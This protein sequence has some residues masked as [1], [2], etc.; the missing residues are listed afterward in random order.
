M[1]YS[2]IH[3][4]KKVGAGYIVLDILAGLFP[5][6]IDAATGSRYSLAQKNIDAVLEKQQ[7]EPV[8]PNDLEKF[9]Y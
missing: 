2:L 6:I 4:K 5:I 3:I 9:L 1:N 8:D 7:K